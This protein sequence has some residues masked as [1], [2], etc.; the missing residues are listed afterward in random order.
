MIE[1]GIPIKFS[2]LFISNLIMLFFL[3]LFPAI[4]NLLACPP[5]IF[6]INSVAIS[7]P[8]KIEFGSTPLSNLCFASVSIVKSR[9]VFR[10]EAGK[11]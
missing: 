1:I 6:K 11:K 3:R 10:I 2:K 8:S 4:T 9:D 7:N 5:H